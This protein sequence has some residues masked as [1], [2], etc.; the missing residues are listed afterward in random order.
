MTDLTTRPTT[1]LTQRNRMG[2][3]LAGTLGLLDVVGLAFPTPEGEDGPPVGILGLCGLIG[4]ATVLLVV[5][6]WRN[7]TRGPIRVIAGLRVLSI[8]AALPAFFVD[9]D[10]WVKIVVAVALVLTVVSLVLMLDRD[11]TRTPVTD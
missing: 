11:R 4:V 6:A 5:R 1:R 7:D 8:V 3:A 9:I 10:P 2:L